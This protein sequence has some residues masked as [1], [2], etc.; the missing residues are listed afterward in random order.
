MDNALFVLF[1][2]VAIVSAVLSVTRKNTVAAAC[3][4]VLLF[5][6]L[7][8]I[9]VLLQAYLVGVIQILVYAGAIMV[10]FLFVI[11]LL[12]LR[13]DELLAH[14]GPRLK[15]LGVL[16]S[17]V[18]FGIVIYA[19]TDAGASR[20]AVAD[21]TTALLRVPGRSPEALTLVQNAQGSHLI[22]GEVRIDGQGRSF[23]VEIRNGNLRSDLLVGMPT[24][25]G[26]SRVVAYPWKAGQPVSL[27]PPEAP[28]GTTVELSL[29]RGGLQARPGGLPDGSPK[30]VGEAL[31][32]KW[33]LPFEIVS[34]LL[35]GAIF[36]AVVL[37]KRRL[38]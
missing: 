35:T 10:L 14:K 26:R 9:Y 2:A 16:L 33:L 37:T 21:R 18:F 11:M 17:A 28:E 12:D 4:L 25:D 29:L 19:V 32:E 22:S 3:W 6:G 30:A 27:H 36:G 5:F 23:G 15:V 7:A 8:G 1:A 24:L 34:L 31:F 38:A 13:N 20:T